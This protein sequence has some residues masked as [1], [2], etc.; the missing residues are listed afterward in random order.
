MK[1]PRIDAVDRE[2]PIVGWVRRCV[3][4]KVEK[5]HDGCYHKHKRD[6]RGIQRTCKECTSKRDRSEQ[7]RSRPR[8]R[9]SPEHYKA[10][11]AKERVRINKYVQDHYRTVRGRFLTLISSARGRAI[12]NGIEHNLDIEWALDC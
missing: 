9:P 12:K 1:R 6:I 3:K 8:V 5:P 11:Y 4:C 7:R 10:R 2:D